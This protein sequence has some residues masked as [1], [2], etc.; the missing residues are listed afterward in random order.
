MVKIIKPPKPN[1]VRLK[2]KSVKTLKRI[3]WERYFSPYI[4]QRD[5]GVCFTCGNTKEW[6]FQHAGHFIP[7]SK[8]SDTEFDETNVHCQCPK[9]NT[10][11]HG[12]LTEYTLKMIDKYGRE[13][14]EELR[15][16]GQ[17]VKRWRIEELESLIEYY[18]I[19]LKNYEI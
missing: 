5:N 15:K 2:K 17:I 16:R 7:K 3:L 18:K 11:K 6:K 8:Y 9:C 14:V 12:N 4:R 13:K 19:K 10:F 1:K